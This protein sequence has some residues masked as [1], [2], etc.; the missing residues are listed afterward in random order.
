MR[1]KRRL[2]K[3]RY[4]FIVYAELI[5]QGE[6]LLGRKEIAAYDTPMFLTATSDRGSG[7]GMIPL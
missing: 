7:N 2:R 1:K 5:L 4:S 6:I 3:K